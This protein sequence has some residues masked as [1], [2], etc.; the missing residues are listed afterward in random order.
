M[1][2][3]PAIAAFSVLVLALPAVAETW[4]AYTQPTDKGLQWSFDADYSYRDAA[5]GRIVV[6]TAI[7]KVGATPRMGPSAPGAA[8]G[9]GFVY[10]LDCK[11]KNLIPMGSYSP[12]KPLEI[13][14]GW[15]DSAPK[16]ADGADDEALMRQVC[17]ASAALPTK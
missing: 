9:V 8:D 17:D 2:R 6:M 13:A 15:R 10:A 12:K 11:A 1:R 3:A 16:K 5:S 4:T 14:G 7:G